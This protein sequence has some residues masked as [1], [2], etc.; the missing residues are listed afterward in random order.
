MKFM[1]KVPRRAFSSAAPDARRRRRRRAH[2]LGRFSA[3]PRDSGSSSPTSEKPR[4]GA[5]CGEGGVHCKH[6]AR[7]RRLGGCRTPVPARGPRAAARLRDRSRPLTVI[8]SRSHPTCPSP[9][10]S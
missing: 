10:G 7:A 6:A 1:T 4:V 8:L 9:Y 5:G 3:E 2:I